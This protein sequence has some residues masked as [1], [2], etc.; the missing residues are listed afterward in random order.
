[1][2]KVTT[3]ISKWRCGLEI[4]F[5]PLIAGQSFSPVKINS[6]WMKMPTGALTVSFRSFRGRFI[7]KAL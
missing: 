7:F 1:L 6:R 3:T 4:S 5:L 2:V